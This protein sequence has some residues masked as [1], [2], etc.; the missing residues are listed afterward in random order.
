MSALLAR[1]WLILLLVVG[2][3]VLYIKTRPTPTQYAT[4]NTTSANP[5]SYRL[6]GLIM[7]VQN[8]GDQLSARQRAGLPPPVLS[9]PSSAQALGGFANVNTGTQVQAEPAQYWGLN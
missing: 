4:A 8:L 6:Q 1:P 2:L 7:Q 3:G 5:L 9:N